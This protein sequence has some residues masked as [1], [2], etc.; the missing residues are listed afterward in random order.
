MKGLVSFLGL[1]ALVSG[2]VSRG[3]MPISH[4]TD[5]T[6]ANPTSATTDVN[7]QSRTQSVESDYSQTPESRV[8]VAV[9][10]VGVLATLLREFEPVLFA[11]SEVANEGIDTPED[12]AQTQEQANDSEADRVRQQQQEPGNSGTLNN[13]LPR[14]D[15]AYTYHTARPDPNLQP[16][17]AIPCNDSRVVSNPKLVCEFSPGVIRMPRLDQ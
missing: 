10:R 11:S 3:T 6:A 4:A 17:E 16:V 8:N 1:V 2:I 12:R 13:S 15:Q 5:S 14:F 9:N 7:P